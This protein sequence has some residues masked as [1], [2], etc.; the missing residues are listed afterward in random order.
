MT[1]MQSP[2]G[3]TTIIDGK[4]FLYFCGTGYLCLQG[5]QRLIDAGCEALR[6]YGIGAATSRSGFGTCPPL[7]ALEE[8][9][10]AFYGTENAFCF[11]SGYSG[12][13]ILVTALADRF[14]ILYMDEAVHYSGHEAAHLSQSPIEVF[15]HRDPGH[16]HELLERTLSAV[17]RPLV[18]TDGIFPVSGDIAPLKDYADLTASYGGAVLVDDAH[19]LGVLG[20]SGRGTA[21][22]FGSNAEHV[23]TTATMSKAIGGHGGVIPCSNEFFARI[24]HECG[25]FDGAS[26]P[27]NAAAAASERGLRIAM[28]E[29]QRR[30]RLQN[31]ARALR[32]GL[33]KLGLDIEDSPVPV[34]CITGKDAGQLQNIQHRLKADGILISFIERYSGVRGSGVLRIAVFSEH[35]PEMIEQLLSEFERFL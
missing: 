28:E 31:N 20:E 4:E 15:R 8:R 33:R 10:A 21:E 34:A 5:D 35:T 16:L 24:R 7:V 11:S 19:A 18:L 32:S 12:P 14:D 26:P 17:Q 1:A 25:Y 29:P 2:P 6:R 22:Y 13:A 27:D 3:P 23:Y 30:K 9:A